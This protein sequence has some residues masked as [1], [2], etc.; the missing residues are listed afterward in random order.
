MNMFARRCLAA[1]AVLMLAGPALAAPPPAGDVNRKT[2]KCKDEAGAVYYSDHYTPENCKGGGAQ[3]NSEG[4]T[5]RKIERQMTPEEAAAVKEKAAREAEEARIA[6]KQA[7]A[8]RVLLETFANEQELTR[9]HQKELTQIDT[10]I[11]AARTA[12]I[13]QEKSLT[14]L[15]NM[16]ADAERSGT[17]V[18]PQVTKNI[19]IVRR[20]VETQKT[21][22]TRKQAQK[23][24]LDRS[25]QGQ[26][27]RYRE[28]ASDKATKG[29][30]APASN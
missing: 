10:E 21:F 8:D 27:K 11:Q 3:L 19:G 6:E 26:L 1:V 13:A 17:K 14:E 28:L 2:Y 18:S 24:D 29:G 9:A 7:A 4:V 25:Y 20:Q 5:V 22:I 12:L 16:A 15:L 23:D 30:K